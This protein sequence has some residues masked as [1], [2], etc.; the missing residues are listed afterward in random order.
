MTKII[1]L[2]EAVTQFQ[3]LAYPDGWTCIECGDEYL[4]DTEGKLVDDY[5]EGT[6]C[7]KCNV[8]MV[9]DGD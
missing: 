4:E 2:A 6:L 7:K 5:I 3:S 1:D 8:E 9:Q